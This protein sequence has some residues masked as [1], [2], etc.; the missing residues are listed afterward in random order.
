[1]VKGWQECIYKKIFGSCF[2]TGQMPPQKRILL[3]RNLLDTQSSGHY[4]QRVE[5][6]D[7][8]GK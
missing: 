8:C 6:G 2:R 1:M 3:I 7:Y 5:E 4:E